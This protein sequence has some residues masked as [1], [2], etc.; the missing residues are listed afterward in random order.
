MTSTAC[1][2]TANTRNK[3]RLFS[4][5]SCQVSL[6]SLSLF[7]VWQQLSQ[8]WR[9][10]Q[11][12]AHDGSVLVQHPAQQSTGRSDR[13]QPTAQTFVPHFV[14][15]TR[16]VSWCETNEGRFWAIDAQTLN[17]WDPHVHKQ[18]SATSDEF[19]QTQAAAAGGVS[20]AATLQT[21]VP[22]LTYFI[23]QFPRL[24]NA[25]LIHRISFP[26]HLQ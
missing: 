22:G 16:W 8:D 20:I 11:E 23:I 1:H 24:Q 25:K 9:T 3:E 5:T 12:A 18:A 19:V 26:A 7:C 10:G 21:K 13:W 6:P 14:S 17:R 2:C 4:R 15:M